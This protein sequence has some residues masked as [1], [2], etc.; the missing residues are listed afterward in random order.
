MS[1][2]KNI[3]NFGLLRL[4]NNGGTSAV[5]NIEFVK[6]ILGSVQLRKTYSLK[7]SYFI[8]VYQK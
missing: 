5:I 4:D 6:T 3:F 2:W 8:C 1:L 7:T